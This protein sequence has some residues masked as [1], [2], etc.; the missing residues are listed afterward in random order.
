MRKT[1]T[2]LAGFLRPSQ[3]QLAVASIANAAYDRGWKDHEAVC[4]TEHDHATAAAA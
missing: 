4:L 2:R 3:R 1:L